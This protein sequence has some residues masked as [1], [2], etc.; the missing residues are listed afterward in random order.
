M[1]PNFGLIIIVM[2]VTPQAEGRIY[3]LACECEELFKKHLSQGHSPLVASLVA[4][5]QQRFLTWT[6]YLGVFARPSQ[7]LD[8]RL[9]TLHDI[10]DIVLRLLGLLKRALLLFEPASSIATDDT[11]IKT[12]GTE[13]TLKP[14]VEKTQDTEE[15]LKSSAESL[16]EIEETLDRLNRLGVAIRQSARLNLNHRVK[17]FTQNVN[18]KDFEH[19]F[20]T[21]VQVLYPN[22]HPSLRS[23]LAR[24]MTD[25]LARII[26]LKSRRLALAT[27]RNEQPQQMAD[28]PE[29][30][31]VQEEAAPTANI[32]HHPPPPLMSQQLPQPIG[33]RTSFSDLS[34]LDTSLFR[35]RLNNI[36]HP[37]SKTRKT[38]ST[39]IKYDN[40]PRPPDQS[41]GEVVV[42]EWCAQPLNREDLD[43]TT[44]RRHVDRDLE[45]YIC[46]SEGCAE[47]STGFSTF[48]DWSDHMQTHGQ[49]WH[50][51][52]YLMPSWICA[53]CEDDHYTFG[54]PENL[55]S[56]MQATHI[57]QFSAEQ[58]QIISRRSKISRC[59]SLNECPLCCFQIQDQDLKTKVVSQ[60]R[61]GEPLEG[62]S[63]KSTRKSIDR[64]SPK[65]HANAGN[66]TTESSSQGAKIMTQHIASHLQALMALTIRIA[67][68]QTDQSVAME[69]SS[70][71]VDS[72]DAFSSSRDEDLPPSSALNDDTS[73]EP[74]PLTSTPI[75]SYQDSSTRRSNDDG[76]QQVIPPESED[77]GKWGDVPRQGEVLAELDVPILEVLTEDTGDTNEETAMGSD[78]GST[79][80]ST[81]DNDG[82]SNQGIPMQDN[83]Q[84]NVYDTLF[85]RASLVRSSTPRRSHLTLM[86]EQNKRLQSQ[87]DRASQSNL[88]TSPL[89]IASN[90]LSPQGPPKVSHDIPF[91]TEGSVSSTPTLTHGIPIAG[92]AGD[93]QDQAVLSPRTTRRNMLETELTE[94]LR[95]QLLWM[96]P[97]AVMTQI[98]LPKRH[99]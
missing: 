76:L 60:K 69:I 2:P 83:L 57:D 3:N 58:I 37:K 68:R 44:W 39:Q 16:T 91:A 97:G 85:R 64:S 52:V 48:E 47:S 25:R 46:L 86:M 42:C 92:N 15:T 31:A 90:D 18:V 22:A 17:L 29:D 95:R 32:T 67:S 13:E 82:L 34:S 99:Y 43:P 30:E 27:R 6:A 8:R 88:A 59:R 94:S 87:G 7:C 70:D 11:E 38:S 74:G 62:N 28:I 40:Y 65:L 54:D 20:T 9:Q 5:Y 53:I 12:Q 98:N 63:N 73:V 77:F 36:W 50:Q 84:R 14:G 4:E 35:S 23:R 78:A 81:V 56:H 49:R 72:D 89:H 10:R 26:F 41:E 45:P 61:T 93:M 33:P 75:L 24:S 96:R 51:D 71:V 19:L 66:S 1:V 79:D 55:L 21:M 80:E